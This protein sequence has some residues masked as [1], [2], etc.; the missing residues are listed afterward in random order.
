MSF[1]C[2]LVAVIVNIQKPA[3]KIGLSD[4]SPLAAPPSLERTAS[5]S[6]SGFAKSFRELP[7]R[8]RRK[9]LDDVEIEY[10]Q[11]TRYFF[12]LRPIMGACWILW[13]ACLSLHLWIC[14]WS[15]LRNHMSKLHQNFCACC[16]WPLLGPPLAP[17]YKLCSSSFMD[18]I[19]FSV[20]SPMVVWHY[21]SS[22]DAVYVWLNIPAAWYW[23]HPVLVVWI[24]IACKGCQWRV[25]D[26]PLP[27][28]L[29]FGRP[30]YRLSLWY[31][32]SSVVS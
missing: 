23:L 22:F 20:T 29:I 21:G 6:Q 9:P 17:M 28:L 27:C 2:F 24:C 3:A 8:Y 26:A 7:T 31:S 14:M 5:S 11:V 12:L 1:V 25:C 18:D 16:L 19:M 10:I 32:M 30:Y 4:V 13:W 15:H